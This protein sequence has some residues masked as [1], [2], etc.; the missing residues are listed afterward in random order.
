MLVDFAG[1]GVPFLVVLLVR[2]FFFI[3]F[4]V[5]SFLFL[6]KIADYDMNV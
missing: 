6:S 4:L 1:G 2:W 5:A 3:V